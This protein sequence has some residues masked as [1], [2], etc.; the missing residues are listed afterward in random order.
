MEAA[1]EFNDEPEDDPPLLWMKVSP[2]LPT[3]EFNC[4]PFLDSR[5]WNGAQKHYFERLMLSFQSLLKMRS[6]GKGIQ[7]R[8]LQLTHYLLSKYHHQTGEQRKYFNRREIVHAKLGW[9]FTARSVVEWWSCVR[10]SM[11]YDIHC[12][13]RMCV[14][15]VYFERQFNRQLRDVWYPLHHLCCERFPHRFDLLQIHN[16]LLK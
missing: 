3:N 4:K 9:T 10:D 5:N 6:V 7:Y 1:E 15:D 2:L 8:N 11:L 12:V 13:F 14:C 16:D